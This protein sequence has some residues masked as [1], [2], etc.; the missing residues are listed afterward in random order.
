M[1]T[2]MLCAFPAALQALATALTPVQA[3]SWHCP[4]TLTLTYRRS[5]SMMQDRWQQAGLR[6]FVIVSFTYNSLPA[7][8]HIWAGLL[9]D[10]RHKPLL[11]SL[12]CRYKA[13]NPSSCSFTRTAI[14]EITCKHQ[15]RGCAVLMQTVNDNDVI[16]SCCCSPFASQPHHLIGAS[17]RG[18]Q[19][20]R[21]QAQAPAA[22]Q[23]QQH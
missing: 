11:P 1:A 15:G 4:C 23:R 9:A 17:A 5:W 18:L 19:A 16:N 13:A 6:R 3:H 14:C 10:V 22:S 21:Q 12:C 8:A 2:P 20:Y 7:Q